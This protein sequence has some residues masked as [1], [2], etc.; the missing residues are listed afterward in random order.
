MSVQEDIERLKARAE[1]AEG[2]LTLYE[3]CCCGDPMKDHGYQSG[4]SPVSMFEH[5]MDMNVQE[6]ERLN[7]RVVTLEADLKGLERFRALR[8]RHKDEMERVVKENIQL[9]RVVGCAECGGSDSHLSFAA[10][11][12]CH[13]TGQ[14]MG[15]LQALYALNQSKLTEPVFCDESSDTHR[16]GCVAD[17]G[18]MD[19]NGGSK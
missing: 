17:F 3:T 18:D 2:R 9:R 8:L 14:Y 16:P 11:P 1:E 12:V 15:D 4:H 7:A 5:T 19:H 13:G 10:C 6:I